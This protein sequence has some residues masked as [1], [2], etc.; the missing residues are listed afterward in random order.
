[1]YRTHFSNEIKP[2]DNVQVA[3]WVHDIR[4]I[5]KLIFITL[6]DREGSVQI[7]GKT[8]VTKPEVFEFLKKI[9]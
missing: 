4:D 7:T 2:E 1:M 3:G 6:R 9:G 8:G 5:G